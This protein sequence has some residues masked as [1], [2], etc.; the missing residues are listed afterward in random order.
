MVSAFSSA[1]VWS[2]NGLFSS[3]C[4]FP[5]SG[6]CSDLSPIGSSSLTNSLAACLRTRTTISIPHLEETLL[7]PLPVLS[8]RPLF[9]SPLPRDQWVELN[10]SERHL[11]R[12]LY[13]DMTRKSPRRLTRFLVAMVA[14][15]VGWKWVITRTIP[16]NAL[17]SPSL[18]C[19][20]F[21]KNQ[22]QKKK[23]LYNYTSLF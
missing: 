18:S 2:R 14:P 5:P 16:S 21:Y 17:I 19:I 6:P 8:L 3:P 9:R 12:V 10:I 11:L 4:R 20:L 15:K 1:G 13:P 22:N 23:N 7:R